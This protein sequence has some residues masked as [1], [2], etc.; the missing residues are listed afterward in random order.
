MP[1][2]WRRHKAPLNE[3][4]ES[5]I[6][7]TSSRTQY[8][9]VRRRQ[10][11]LAASYQHFA[12]TVRHHEIPRVTHKDLQIELPAFLVVNALAVVTLL[13]CFASS[14][15]LTLR[16]LLLAEML[17]CEFPPF[18]SRWTLLVTVLL[19]IKRKSLAQIAVGMAV[20]SWVSRLDWEY[21]WL[22]IGHWIDREKGVDRH[23]VSTAL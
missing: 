5:C 15:D 7:S 3:D 10:R 8:S 13:V 9:F 11:K 1:K 22:R 16:L 21:A 4:G 12:S 23:D 17:L 6:V 14:P 20:F 2:L 19:P 18:F